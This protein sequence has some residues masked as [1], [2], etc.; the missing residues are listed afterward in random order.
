[1]SNSN[2]QIVLNQFDLYKVLKLTSNATPSQIKK[3]YY[4]LAKI[5]HP[6]KGGDKKKFYIISVAYKV[7]YDSQRREAYDE[8]Y[9]NSG[10]NKRT[11]ED[12]QD[13]YKKEL[14][15]KVQIEKLDMT[16]K[17]AKKKF[18]EAFQKNKDVES[19]YIYDVEDKIIEKDMSSYLK[20]NVEIKNYLSQNVNL[21]RGSYFDTET[22]NEVFHDVK[23]DYMK[24]E[25]VKDVICYN[26]SGQQLI[27]SYGGLREDGRLERFESDIPKE[28]ID[29]NSKLKSVNIQDYRM[30]EKK[31]QMRVESESARV[32]NQ[33]V[34]DLQFQRSIK[35][36]PQSSDEV[37]DE[38]LNSFDF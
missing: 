14:K 28:Y 36:N 5:Y 33:K 9:Y 34:N 22:F 15:S 32:M 31:H 21:F 2:L 29:I 35:I 38:Y 11:L 7:L 8:K 10:K 13:E 24:E 16:K 27:R 26:Q 18:N 25:P 23:E 6:D 17:D 20:S 4:E 30:R 19:D 3:S 1:M 12:L 37:Q